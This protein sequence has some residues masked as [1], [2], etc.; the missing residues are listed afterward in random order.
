[1]R[2]LAVFATALVL[3]TCQPGDQMTPESADSQAT[4]GLLV[5]DLDPVVATVT[6]VKKVRLLV[7]EQAVADLALPRS[8]ALEGHPTWPIAGDRQVTVSLELVMGEYVWPG[9]TLAVDVAAGESVR[10]RAERDPRGRAALRL[11]GRVDLQPDDGATVDYADVNRGQAWLQRLGDVPAITLAGILADPQIAVITPTATENSNAASLGPLVAWRAIGDAK[12]ASAAAGTDSKIDGTRMLKPADQEAVSAES[13]AVAGAHCDAA[14]Q[15][16]EVAKEDVSA[17]PMDR[18]IPAYLRYYSF[19]TC[20]SAVVDRAYQLSTTDGRRHTG[21]TDRFG[22]VMI[23]DV[24]H[25]RVDYGP[26]QRERKRAYPFI[27]G[28]PETRTAILRALETDEPNDVLTALLDL[29]AQ[30]LPSARARLLALL[31][32]DNP[33]IWRNAAMTLSRLPG[34][35]LAGLEQLGPPP[36][37]A[38]GLQRHLTIHGALRHPEAIGWLARQLSDGLPAARVVSAWGIG[39][40]GHPRGLNALEKAASDTDPAVRAEVAL[41]LGR[42]GHQG[43]METLETLLGDAD[44]AV[45]RRAAEAVQLLQM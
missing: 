14:K 1:M 11:D 41:A 34:G 3:A 36:R 17:P 35:A 23:R 22:M 13:A 28:D 40:I 10:L 18:P 21:H 44:S 30:P 31:E 39:F 37:D 2:R 6:S 8:G 25:A 27:A 24:E 33:V 12:V 19:C 5:I 4:T 32:H 16:E 45:A 9:P 20:G 7:D 42:I 38:A 15:A 43:A 26:S 29:Q